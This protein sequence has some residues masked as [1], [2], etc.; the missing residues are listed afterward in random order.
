MCK[1]N[2][3]FLIFLILG[4]TSPLLAKTKKA[5][6]E[7]AP[8]RQEM[9]SISKTIRSLGPLITSEAEFISEK[10]HKLIQKNLNDLSMYFSKLKIHPAMEMQ[11]LAINE[12]VITEQLD[13]SAKLFTNKKKSD[14]RAKLHASLNLCVHCHT[15][16]PG[17][18]Q[19]KLITEKEI[20]GYKLSPF[21]KADLYF[22]T[23]DYDRALTIYDNFLKNSK[24]DDNDEF[25]Y[26]SLERELIYFV[27]MKKSFPLAKSHLEELLK[28]KNFNDKITHEVNDWIVALSGKNLWENFDPGKTTDEEMA[29]FMQSFITDEE[30]GPIFS[31]TNSSEVYDLNLSYI[32]MDYYNL[33]P[34]TKLGGRILYWLAVLDKKINDD[35]FFS[36]GDF[37]LLA[38][39]E[40]YNKDPIAKECYESYIE[41]MELIFESKGK[42]K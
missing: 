23:R 37:Y 33:H 28:G 13:Q 40:K 22:I 2:H 29:K 35:L 17:I 20:E 9:T 38:C 39:M 18:K 7:P 8:I 15:Q 10:N 41:D 3:L 27:K 4:F 42:V 14:A 21:E 32:L 34:E 25:I 12:H 19:A 6:M 30:E 26:K 31:P 1:L 24:K 36:L 16:A 5:K 11:G